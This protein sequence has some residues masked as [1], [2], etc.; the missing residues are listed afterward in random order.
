MSSSSPPLSSQTTGA[1]VSSSTA[2]IMTSTTPATLAS[3]ITVRLSRT[4]FLLWKS[5]VVP[6]LRGAGLYGYLDGTQK[7][8]STTIVEGTGD[9]EHQVPNPAYTRWYLQDQSILGG[10]RS[11]M[12]EDVLAQITREETSADAWNSL[13]AM[14]SAQNQGNAIGIRTQLATCR[15]HDMPAS[16][17]YH[18]MVSMA[19]TLANIGQPLKDADLISYILAGIGPAYN[20]LFSAVTILSNTRAVS[21]SEFYSYLLAHEAR[22]AMTAGSGSTDFQSSANAVTRSNDNPPRRNDNNNQGRA[23]VVV[24]A[25]AAVAVDVATTTTTTVR[26]ARCVASTGTL[27]FVAATASI[28]RSSLRSTMAAMVQTITREATIRVV[29]TIMVATPPCSVVTKLSLG[30]WTAAPQTISRATSTA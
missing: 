28:T 10:L 23:A 21:L 9:A 11:S 18:K 19:D 20:D 26:G 1:I 17:Y 16:D 7:A 24:A 3:A 29:A 27:P 15:R 25:A 22:L 13:H 4:N 12:T 6:T 8:P 5:Q 30:S 2:S 14:F